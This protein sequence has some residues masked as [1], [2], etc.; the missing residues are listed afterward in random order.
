[1]ELQNC[2]IYYNTTTEL[3]LSFMLDIDQGGCLCARETPPK[4]HNTIVL[5]LPCNDDWIAKVGRSEGGMG[6]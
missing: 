5:T 2:T 4:T 6:R 1:M 3:L